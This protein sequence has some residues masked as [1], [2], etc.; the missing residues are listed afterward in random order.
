MRE[1][2]SYFEEQGSFEVAWAARREIK[3]ILSQFGYSVA[4]G[5]ANVREIAPLIPIDAVR[6][7]PILL[8]V[9]RDIVREKGRWP[10]YEKGLD[11]VALIEELIK[12]LS[13]LLK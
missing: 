4:Y 9:E 6:V 1:F 8:P 7:W 12:K 2:R 5:V 13:P 11:D 3:T 10:L